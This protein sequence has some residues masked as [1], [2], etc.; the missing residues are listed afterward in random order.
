[1]DRPTDQGDIRA[2]GVRAHGVVSELTEWCQSSRSGVRAH[3][4]V[5]EL[6]ECS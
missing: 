2:H 6:T 5:S 3:G 1:L 4:V